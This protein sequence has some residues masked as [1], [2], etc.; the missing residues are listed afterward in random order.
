MCIATMASETRWQNHF[1]Q[2]LRWKSHA[3][4]HGNQ[5]GVSYFYCMGK[6]LYKNVVGQEVLWVLGSWWPFQESLHGATEPDAWVKKA[7][8]EVI[9]S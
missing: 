1:W 9:N 6:L 4:A 5:E 8:G 7:A 2:K 3:F